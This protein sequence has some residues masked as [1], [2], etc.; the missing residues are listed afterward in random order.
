MAQ[1]KS[2]SL[3]ILNRPPT[4]LS[5]ATAGALTD[6]NIKEIACFLR[7]NSPLVTILSLSHT[8]D[9]G[10]RAQL[11]LNALTQNTHIKELNMRNCDLGAPE[12]D[13]IGLYLKK[14]TILKLDIS[15]NYSELTQNYYWYVSHLTKSERRA[16]HYP[17][18]DPLASFLA[19][20]ASCQ[21]LTELVITNTDHF[22]GG[23]LKALE[24]NKSLTAL[25]Y[26]HNPSTFSMVDRSN[27]K[28]LGSPSRLLGCN[29]N[30][31]AVWMRSTATVTSLALSITQYDWVN[32][33]CP[34]LEAIGTNKYL[35]RLTAKC[36]YG[37]D[38][39]VDEAL[40]IM[41][42]TNTA[43]TSLNLVGCHV[44]D[45][46]ALVM[47]DAL[48]S[49]ASLTELTVDQSTL[50]TKGLASLLSSNLTRLAVGPGCS[51]KVDCPFSPTLRSLVLS[52]QRL[53]S[54]IIPP[55]CNLRELNV[56]DTPV[57]E[58]VIPPGSYLSTINAARTL[59]DTFTIPP[60]SRLVS[61]RLTAPTLTSFTIVGPCRLETL[62]ISGHLDVLPLDLMPLLTRLKVTNMPQ[63]DIESLINGLHESVTDL[64]IDNANLNDESVVALAD[65]IV[66]PVCKLTHLVIGR[67]TVTATGIA[68]LQAVLNQNTS[69]VKSNINLEPYVAI[70]NLQ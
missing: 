53:R 17:L 51:R 36:L 9:L 5:F 30:D 31:M 2:Y 61:L 70:E 37:D 13:L 45:T 15:C 19:G 24:A 6:D 58:L 52:R 49:N 66:S 41:L 56:S 57:C 7:S 29:A 14:H 54:I 26:A 32:K 33:V 35:Q 38:R 63:L 18:A 21:S 11:I 46:R 28:H 3:S 12:L 55:G 67:H 68:I 50:R 23:L 39:Y 4:H 22:P 44:S 34:L 40:A 42:K 69:L 60:D 62:E 48:L 27:I 59:I 10:P 43:L 1:P 64:E 47:A 25:T 16:K 8:N 65:F 20:L